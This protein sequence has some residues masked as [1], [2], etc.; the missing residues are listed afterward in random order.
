ME[1]DEPEDDFDEEELEDPEAEEIDEIFEAGVVYKGKERT[2]KERIASSF[3]GRL[4]KTRMI[5]ARAKQLEAGAASTIPRNRLKSGDIL[6]IAKQEVRER[7]C[8]IKIV[9]KFP[10]G[11]YEVWGIQDFEWI[12]KD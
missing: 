11:S 6:E 10:D 12:A 8:P 3:L 7:I 5:S 1:Y 9:R 4:A 2:G